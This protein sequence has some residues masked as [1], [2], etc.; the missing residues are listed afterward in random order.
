[1]SRNRKYVLATSWNCSNKFTGRKV[2]MLYFEVRMQ[3]LWWGK[4]NGWRFHMHRWQGKKRSSK[5]CIFWGQ[6]DGRLT[7]YWN[8]SL[9]SRLLALTLLSSSAQRVRMEWHHNR[10]VTECTQDAVTVILKKLIEQKRTF[11]GEHISPRVALSVIARER[12]R[13]HRVWALINKSMISISPSAFESTIPSPQ[14]VEHK[15][16]IRFN[17]V[18]W[19]L[20]HCLHQSITSFGYL[21]KQISAHFP[22]L[23]HLPCS[24]APDYFRFLGMLT[25]SSLEVPFPPYLAFIILMR[26]LFIGNTGLFCS[27]AACTN[28][29]QREDGGR[30]K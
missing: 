16:L 11:R 15:R 19:L 23:C 1:M 28:K 5:F 29:V 7:A 25:Q 13:I 10:D 4:Y 24:L 21:T 14:T 27:L 3:L 30:A 8:F 18:Q 9:Y 22:M 2:M 12:Q 26:L 6:D 17:P 20:I